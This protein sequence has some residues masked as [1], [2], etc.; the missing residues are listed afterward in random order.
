MVLRDK[1]KL[2]S[3]LA[4]ALSIVEGWSIKDDSRL[5]CS[6]ADLVTL[7]EKTKG[8]RFLKKNQGKIKLLRGKYYVLGEKASATEDLKETMKTYMKKFDEGFENWKN[9][10]DT[11]YELKDDGDFFKCSCPYGLKRYFCKHNIGLSIKLKNYKVPDNAISVP[12]D[13]KRR[14]GRP[15]KNKGWWSRE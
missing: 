2:G 14:R 1:Q 13:E 15:A 6:L 4:N 8:Y 11:I 9:L 5:Y 7:E 12:L 10:K 3:F